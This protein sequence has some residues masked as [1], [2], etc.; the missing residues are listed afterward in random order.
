[1][2]ILF[3][4]SLSPGLG[5]GRSSPVLYVT[6][7]EMAHPIGRRTR[8]NAGV[9]SAGREPGKVWSSPWVAKADSKTDSA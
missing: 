1:M 4:K 7:L 8:M 9:H 2:G 5:H 3:M 6:G